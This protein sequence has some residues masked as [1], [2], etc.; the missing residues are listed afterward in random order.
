MRLSRALVTIAVGF[1][2][3]VFVQS[4]FGF[5]WWW[6]LGSV[7]LAI[8]AGAV[9]IAYGSR[10]GLF[11]FFFLLAFSLGLVRG[12]TYH[13]NFAR[14]EKTFWNSSRAFL[15]DR[16]KSILPQ[17]EGA[18][19]NAMVLGYEKDVS[20]KIKTDFNRTGT[21]HVVAISGMNISIVAMLIMSLGLSLGLWRQQAFWLAVAG[22]AAFVLLVGSPPSALRAGI[23]GIILLWA[24]NRG[25]LVQAWRPLVIAAFLMVVLN[26]TLLNLDIGFQLSFLAVLGIIYFKN[27]WARVLFWLP[28]KPARELVVLSMAAQTTTWPIILYNFGSLSVISPIANVF[29]VPILTPI[30]FLGLGFVIFSFWPWPAQFF[31]WPAWLILKITIKLV[32]F[33]G[34]FGWA[35]AD[36]GKSGLMVFLFYPALYLFWRYSENRGYNDPTN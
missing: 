5:L 4:V 2:A 33:F 28:I 6:V 29:V 26:P 18:L 13:Q 27:F 11:V 8:A 20:A 35:S 17:D 7:V 31:L 34:S 12:G 36:L 16:V 21:R 30:M 25:R 14:G 22:V 1:L 15:V 32:E 23:M 10:W 3:G 19:F 9:D 24:Q